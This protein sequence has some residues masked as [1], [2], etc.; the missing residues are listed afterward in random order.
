MKYWGVVFCIGMLWSCKPKSSSPEEIIQPQYAK[1][2]YFSTQ[3]GDTTLHI[4]QG[5]DTIALQ[6]K[7]GQQFHL[8][9]TTQVGYFDLLGNTSDIKGVVYP[10][11]VTYPSLQARWQQGQLI[12][13]N[14]GHGEIDQELL[15]S[16]TADYVLYSPFDPLDF[17]L[18]TS[19]EKIPFLDYAEEHPLGRLEWIKVIGFLSSRAAPAENVF[20][21]KAQQYASEICKIEQPQK[22]VIGSW[23]GEY[24]YING[25]KSTINQTLLDAGFQT[26]SPEKQG[27]VQWDKEMLW[28]KLSDIDHLIWITTTQQKPQLEKEMLQPESWQKKWGVTPHFILIDTCAYFQ[29]AIVAPEKLLRDL[30]HLNDGQIKTFVTN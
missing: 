22:V 28:S 6:K 29:Q 1:L 12:Q 17:A 19:T 23:D 25:Q 10:E 14:P 24:F 9:S 30:K 4:I 8:L 18:P 5:G 16:Q 7:N 21:E 15:W 27:N 2:F 11:E 20:K 3:F 13:L 26:L